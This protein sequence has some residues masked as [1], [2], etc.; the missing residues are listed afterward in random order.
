MNKN[1]AL[2]LLDAGHGGMIN[3]KY[4]TPGKRS[5]IWDDDTQY[6]EGVGNRLIREE[7]MKLL[8][9]ECINY[10]T[11]NPGEAD[12]SLG[13]RVKI[14]NAH[15]RKRGTS[16]CLLISI[17]SDAWKKPE[18][19]GWS[20][21][22]TKGQTASDLFAEI[23]YEETQKVFP[24]ETFRSDTRD[25]DPDKEADFYI[26]S[27]TLCPAVLSENFF[28]TNPEECKNILMNKQGR[29]KIA[30]AHVNAILRWVNE[31]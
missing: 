25:G 2:I 28:M 3:S 18:A 12:M 19:H 11:V 13:E 7:I 14:V 20:C 30:T 29:K 6:F 15:C 9:A 26:I 17:H 8:D 16:N 31:G 10:I 23:L 4:V 27:K 21:Y 5:P 24:N 1:Q 22:T